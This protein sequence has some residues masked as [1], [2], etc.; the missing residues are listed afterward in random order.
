MR[1]V[2]KP[3]LI[4][5]VFLSLAGVS[6]AKEWRGIVPLQ[7]TRQDVTRLLGNP[8]DANSIRANYSLENEDV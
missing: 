4:T 6:S 3:L 2:L 7:S 5:L 1:Y 8:S